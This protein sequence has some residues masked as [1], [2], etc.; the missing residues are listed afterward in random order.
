MQTRILLNLALLLIIAALVALVMYEPGIET[1]PA[2]AKLSALK[3]EDIAHLKIAIKNESPIILEKAA[4]Q[5]WLQTPV[6]LRADETTVKSIL[7][8]L[9]ETSYADYPA[10][11]FDLATVGLSEPQIQLWFNETEIRL[12]KRNPLQQQRYAQIGDRVHMITDKVSHRLSGDYSRYVSRALLPEGARIQ[13][14]ELPELRL[15]QIE[16]KWEV[17]P[18]QPAA[19]A[20]D[21]QIL[22]D[23]WR[24]ARAMD[25]APYQSAESEGKI[26]IDLGGETAEFD[27]LETAPEFIL[28]RKDLGVQ[29]YMPDSVMGQLLRLGTREATPKP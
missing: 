21:L 17:E 20:D 26:R 16:G 14:L 19:S 9:D 25:V 6:R 10:A 11:S 7:T 22:I 2:A 24:Q 29:Y 4:D 3:A 28:G 12:G 18:A 15:A 13:R 23:H 5:W 1:P 27:I 8:L